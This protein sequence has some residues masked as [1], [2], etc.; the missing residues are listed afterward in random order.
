LA[1]PR[2]TPRLAGP[3]ALRRTE[4]D[5]YTVTGR[6][7]QLS[8]E[9]L[10]RLGQIQLYHR[11]LTTEQAHMLLAALTWTADPAGYREQRTAHPRIRVRM[12]HSDWS[13][14]PRRCQRPARA[15]SE[16][17]AYNG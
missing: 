6:L 1:T 9:Q 3:V 4:A 17:N 8:G 12:N 16:R 11:A 14:N 15:R 10:Q 7:D 5:T 13:T 2:T